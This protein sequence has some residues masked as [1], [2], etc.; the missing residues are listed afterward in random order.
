MLQKRT[1][2]VSHQ[3][4]KVVKVE[5]FQC[6]TQL[7]KGCSHYSEYHTFWN[8]PWSLSLAHYLA[9]PKVYSISGRIRF[10]VPW[11]KQSNC[12]IT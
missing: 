6:R 4:F 12:Q 9:L 8:L 11:R 10:Q 2:N 3:K 5:I 1:V 7:I